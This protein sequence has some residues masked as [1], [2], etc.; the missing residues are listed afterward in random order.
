M[1]S[2]E[3]DSAD[4]SPERA[5]AGR[6]FVAELTRDLERIDSEELRGR[7]RFP[8][9][10]E[11][12]HAPAQFRSILAIT[13]RALAQWGS[14]PAETAAEIEQ[15]L[16]RLLEIIGEIEARPLLHEADM[17]AD[18]RRVS[19]EIKER[20]NALH[21]F[22]G[23]TVEPLVGAMKSSPEGDGPSEHEIEN[24]RRTREEL[25]RSKK[26]IAELEAR[27]DQIDAEL[28]SRRELIEAARLESGTT[29]AQYLAKAYVEQAETHE[30]DWK[31]WGVGL[32]AST[33]TALVGGYAVLKHN[34]PA[35]NASTAQIVSHVALDLLIIGLLIYVVRLTSLQFSVHRHLAAVAR[36]KAAA[37]DTFSQIVSSGSSSE[38]RDRLA[39]VLAQYVF[40]SSDTG[41]LDSAGDQV[42]LP[43][44]LAGPVAQRIN[45]VRAGASS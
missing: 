1:H 36:N 32:I 19:N 2:G 11:L 39:E 34:H 12:T 8:A 26:E 28:E 24:I 17:P 14:L 4:Q 16:M 40:V 30:R 27:Y 3:P 45:G 37:L 41:F 15:G 21:A 6:Q 23:D 25:D 18:S 20:L 31:Y 9:K 35:D 43:E 7:G 29:G 13:Q 38:T 44:R 10:H 22:F 33:L 5:P 42:T